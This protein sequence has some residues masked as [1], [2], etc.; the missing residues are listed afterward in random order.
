[1]ARRVAR[2]RNLFDAGREIEAIV[3]KVKRVRG[4]NRLK[5]GFEMHGIRYEVKSAFLRWSKTPTFSEGTR[6]PVLVDPAH[7]KRAV[8]LALY[9]DPGVVQSSDRPA[10]EASRS[11]VN[12][13]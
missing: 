3:R 5:L 10:T 4:G 13:R 2:V 11:S 1:M 7:P 8:P 9:A 12:A 6:I